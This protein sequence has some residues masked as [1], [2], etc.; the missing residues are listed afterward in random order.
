MFSFCRLFQE[1][2]VYFLRRGMEVGFF[3]GRL[4]W[5]MCQNRI[6]VIKVFVT[7]KHVMF[8]RFLV[9]P[10]GKDLQN[11]RDPPMMEKNM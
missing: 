7:P 3:K 8:V 5:S 10:R 2:T 6:L 4:L 9:N 1:M 11:Q